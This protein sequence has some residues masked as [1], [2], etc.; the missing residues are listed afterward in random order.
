[1]GERHDL[2]RKTNRTL[3]LPDVRLLL[4]VLGQS[5]TCR[6]IVPS[7]TRIG[8]LEGRRHPGVYRGESVVDASKSRKRSLG[9]TV[10]C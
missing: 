10:L 8:A 7:A 2:C 4:T 9:L 6:V 3:K 1:M 5:G